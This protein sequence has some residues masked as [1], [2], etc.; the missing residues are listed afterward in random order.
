MLKEEYK[1]PAKRG[2]EKFGTPISQWTDAMWD[3]LMEGDQDET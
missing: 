1:E 2:W 3:E